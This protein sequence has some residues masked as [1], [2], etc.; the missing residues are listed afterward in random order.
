MKHLFIVLKG[1]TPAELH[2]SVKHYSSCPIFTRF[3]A[4]EKTSNLL[5]IFFSAKLTS[6][7]T[8]LLQAKSSSY[9]DW[10]KQTVFKMA[11]ITTGLLFASV[12][13]LQIRL[14]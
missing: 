1:L 12:F 6:K 5:D 9:V 13:G 11:R 10:V 4:T 14:L 7:A 8:A 2:L 3:R